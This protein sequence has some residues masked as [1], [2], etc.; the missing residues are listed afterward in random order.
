MTLAGEVMGDRVGYSLMVC[1]A[2]FPSI[3]AFMAGVSRCRKG[4]RLGRVGSD[5]PV[6]K[7]GD[8]CSTVSPRIA[9]GRPY[10]VVARGTPR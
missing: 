9:T 8:R 1:L 2:S 3:S 10:C 4:W 6:Q 5:N 7:S